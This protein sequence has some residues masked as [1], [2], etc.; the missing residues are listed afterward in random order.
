MRQNQEGAVLIVALLLLLVT[1]FIG[2]S[3][4]EGSNLESKM[5]TA[6]EVKELTFQS[7][8][9]AIEF[10]LDNQ[11]VLGTAY[12]R[13]LMDM[14]ATG[15]PGWPTVTHTFPYNSYI[16]AE[17]EARFQS[18]ATTVGYSIRKGAAG[19][20]TYYYEVEGTASRANTNISSTHT[21]GIFVE[22]P[23]L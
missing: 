8:E 1:T 5:A 12:A 14:T 20:A 19:I 15:W 21:Q 22:G 6:R 4:M 17:S 18:T 3:A 11:P 7:A 23:S 13:S 2:F 10:T 16:A 9:A